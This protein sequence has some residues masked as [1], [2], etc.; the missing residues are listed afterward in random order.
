MYPSIY[1]THAGACV[2][3]QN[4][5]DNYLNSW[6]ATGRMQIVLKPWLYCKAKMS[7]G[8][9]LHHWQLWILGGR[10]NYCRYVYSLS[11]PMPL[12]LEQLATLSTMFVSSESIT[13][14]RLTN[15]IHQSE[16]T[17][18]IIIE[19][20][21]ALTQTMLA[22][23]CQCFAVY[24]IGRINTKHTQVFMHYDPIY[25]ILSVPVIIMITLLCNHCYL[26]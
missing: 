7:N 11:I 6:L 18:C 2:H 9:V 12:L 21:S 24:G 25:R 15:P 19:L 14:P 23:K 5:T 8:I 16:Q 10:Y 1:P 22:R 3:D 4:T 17:P 20:D 26:W 13:R